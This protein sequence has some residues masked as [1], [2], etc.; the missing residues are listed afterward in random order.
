MVSRGLYRTFFCP[1]FL[2]VTFEMLDS[3]VTIRRDAEE[4][5]GSGYDNG[6]MAVRKEHQRQ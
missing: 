3:Y 4:D 2:V 5:G 6:A 1:S